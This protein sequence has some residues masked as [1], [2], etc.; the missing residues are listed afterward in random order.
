MILSLPR[1]HVWGWI[2]LLPPPS[3]GRAK[4]DSLPP[5]RVCLD[6]VCPWLQLCAQIAHIVRRYLCTVVFELA[7][8]LNTS[9]QCPFWAVPWVTILSSWAGFEVASIFPSCLKDHF[10]VRQFSLERLQQYLDFRVGSIVDVLHAPVLS[11]STLQSTP[12]R[13]SSAT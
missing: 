13:T 11:W 7:F 2:L 8:L 5:C 1:C 4:Q 9:S 10:C 6:L 3:V 12:R